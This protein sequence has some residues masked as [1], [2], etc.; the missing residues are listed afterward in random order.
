IEGPETFAHELGHNFSLLHAP[1]GGPADAD[2]QFPDSNGGIGHYGF[3]LST[4]QVKLPNVEKDLMTYCG[5]EWISDY[6]YVKAFG[7][8]RTYDITRTGPRAVQDALLVWG[9]IQDGELVLEPAFRLDMIPRE[10][11]GNGPYRLRGLD[12][13]GAEI[14]SYR[15]D[16]E[17]VDHIGVESFAF[18]IP[19]RVAQADR[20]AEIVLNGPQGQLRRQRSDA[21]AAPALRQFRPD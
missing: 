4:G 7:H 2:P 17:D 5:P 14:F 13:S 21:P 19:E 3:D 9:G 15:F 16:T 1:C 11:S 10:P 20:L 12:A 18:A 8:R 6:S